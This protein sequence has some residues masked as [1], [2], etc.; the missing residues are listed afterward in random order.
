MKRMATVVLSLCAAFAQQP[1]PT[2]KLP[3]IKYV[4]DFD[5]ISPQHQQVVID[6]EGNGLYVSSDQPTDSGAEPAR[7]SREFTVTPATRDEIVRLAKEAKHFHGDFDYKKSKI[8]FTGSKTL[9]YLDEKTTASTTFNWSD[10]AAIRQLTEIFTGICTTLEAE[11]RLKHM[12][13][14]DKLGLDLELKN[15]L[16]AAKDGRLRE[17]QI[18]EETLHEVAADAS[19]MAPARR[20]AEQLAILAKHPVQ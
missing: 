13:R 1:S 16:S 8:A 5:K 2:L 17:I 18:I 4:L 19:V 20:R 14:F 9:S 7:Y 12:Q 3:Q 10:N 15:L 6:A 11:P